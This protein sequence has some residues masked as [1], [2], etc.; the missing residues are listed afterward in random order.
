MLEE[1]KTAAREKMEAMKKELNK[2]VGAAEAP[3]ASGGAG[4]A[5]AFALYD[6]GDVKSRHNQ[7]VR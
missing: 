2:N 3:A 7:L 4:E 1:A 6:G 5:I